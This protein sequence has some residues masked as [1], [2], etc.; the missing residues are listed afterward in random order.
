MPFYSIRHSQKSL[1]RTHT[2]SSKLDKAQLLI[3]GTGDLRE[4]LEKQIIELNLTYKVKL[5]GYSSD[6]EL[7]ALL[8]S[9]D[10]FFLPSLEGTEAFGVLLSKFIL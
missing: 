10:C 4:G 2:P 7:I 1:T 9:C 6:A 8:A 3:V 5:L